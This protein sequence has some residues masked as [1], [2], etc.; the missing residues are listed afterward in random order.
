MLRSK[1]DQ[2]NG[3]NK[4]KGG[5][6]T[7]RWGRWLLPD[8]SRRVLT[9]FDSAADGFSVLS[10]AGFATPETK[11]M[12][13]AAICSAGEP[14]GG[15]ERVARAAGALGGSAVAAASK[16][17]VGM[18]KYCTAACGPEVLTSGFS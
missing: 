3:R 15:P 10:C 5:K 11:R 1:A 18:A 9:F 8:G 17:A 14:G 7:W 13:S 12:C 4:L 6:A 16:A 2:K